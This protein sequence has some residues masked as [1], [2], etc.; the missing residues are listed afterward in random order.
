MDDF[1]RR[2]LRELQEDSGRPIAVLA[3]RIGLSPSACHRR[4]RL[5]EERGIV[6]GYRATLDPAALGLT[7][8]VFVDISL[9]AQDEPAFSAFEAA[10]TRY[11]EILECWLVAGRADYHLRI[12][13]ADMADFDRIHRGVLTRLPGVASMQSR[14]A[15]RRIKDWRGYPIR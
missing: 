8:E 15:L 14:F 1:D 10:V 13:A 2:L 3:E 12:M 11:P 6:S 4:V 5:L 7:M 9:Q